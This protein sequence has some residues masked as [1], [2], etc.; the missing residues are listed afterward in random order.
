MERKLLND[1]ETAFVKMFSQ[2]INGRISSPKRVGDEL[3]NDH[4]YLVQEK[5]KVALAFIERLALNW[6]QGSFDARNEWACQL[7]ADMID[8]LIEKGLYFPSDNYKY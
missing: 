2:F 8:G 4:R 5:F 6:H 3:A 7:A 1:E